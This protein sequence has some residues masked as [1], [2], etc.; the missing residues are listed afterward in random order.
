MSLIV[1]CGSSLFIKL[2]ENTALPLT[3][4]NVGKSDRLSPAAFVGEAER[5]SGRV[6]SSLHHNQ[7]KH[8]ETSSEY[9]KYST[10]PQGSEN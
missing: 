10:Y 4:A 9:L 8:K 6:D 1:V 5:L 7:E 3:S 2:V